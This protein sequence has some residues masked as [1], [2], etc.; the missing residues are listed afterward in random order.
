[1]GPSLTILCK[2]GT[3]A[4]GLA[5]LGKFGEI[6]KDLDSPVNNLYNAY[7]AYGRCEPKSIP[8]ETSAK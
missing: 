6:R 5:R 7:N 2:I 8:G 3:D 1:M 4:E